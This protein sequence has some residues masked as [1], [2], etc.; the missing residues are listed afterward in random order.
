MNLLCPENKA[1]MFLTGTT[2]SKK[3]I[4]V[5]LSRTSK[6]AL[7]LRQSVSWVQSLCEVIHVYFLDSSIRV[8]E[9]FVVLVSWFRCP[10]YC[11]LCFGA[12]CIAVFVLVLVVLVSCR[13]RCS[14]Y[15]CLGFGAHWNLWSRIY[16]CILP[17]PKS[18][19]S[20]TTTL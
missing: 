5:W 20:E 13:F 9:Q 8:R 15:S 7:Q 11:Y 1:D 19:N 16:N 14:W 6:A 4:W 2:H 12:R 17:S 10:S 18:M 3:R